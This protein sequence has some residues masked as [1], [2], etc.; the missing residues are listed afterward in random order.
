MI[1]GGISS[2]SN[3]NGI[4]KFKMSFGGEY[5]KYFNVFAICSKKAKIQ[6][7][8]KNGLKR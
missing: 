6:Y 4:D 3:P 1:G 8:I 2:Y 7:Y 5:R